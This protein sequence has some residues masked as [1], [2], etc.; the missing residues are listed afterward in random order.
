MELGREASFELE[1]ANC[2]E[3]CGHREE[4]QFDRDVVEVKELEGWGEMAE[5]VVQVARRDD[6]SG[7]LAS[8]HMEGPKGGSEGSE[9]GT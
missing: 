7:E 9:T 4:K 1:G 8:I 6:I 3:L 2:G 5:M